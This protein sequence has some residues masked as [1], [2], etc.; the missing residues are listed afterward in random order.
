M[1]IT[2]DDT[3]GLEIKPAESNSPIVFQEFVFETASF[4]SCHAATV[5]ELPSGEL[6]CA[7]FGGTVESHPDVEIR[8]A[9]KPPGGVW[10]AP[11]SVADGVRSESERLSTGNPVL[12]QPKDGDVV[13]VAAG[14]DHHTRSSSDDP[15]V[16]AWYVTDRSSLAPEN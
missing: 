12:F 13:V 5:L 15:L 4:P 6:L 11:V 16:A 7:F 3:N 10:T 1:M 8:L 9:R 14:E 2:D